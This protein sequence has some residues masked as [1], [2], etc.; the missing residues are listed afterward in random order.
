[1]NSNSEHDTFFMRRALEL[2]T[3]G[4]GMVAPNPMVGCVV[5]YNNQ[6]IGEGWHRQYGQPHAEVNAI[7]S[8]ADKSLLSLSTVYVTL[9]PCSH[10]GKTPPCA[11]LLIHHQVKRVV[12]CN[13]DINPL[14]G[15]KGIE[16]LRQ[17]GI[18]VTTGVLENEGR[19]LNRRFFCFIEKQRPYLILKWAESADGFVA[20]PNFEPTPISNQLSRKW[21]HQW[22]SQEDA[23]MVGTRTAL[24]DNPRLNVRDWSGRNPVRVVIDKQ[25]SLSNALH[26][27]DQSQPTL[28]YNHVQDRQESDLSWIKTP[29]EINLIDAILAN[30]YQRKIQSVLV[31]GGTHLL[32]SFLAQDLW[33]EIR[34]IQ[35]PNYLQ[36][37]IKAPD[38]KAT[39]LFSQIN[40]MGDVLRIYRR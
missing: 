23:I 19:V 34:V 20:K 36:E 40:L 15:G 7:A 4:Q 25:L 3:L 27:F 32:E 33:D 14:V 37:G 6:V 17:S 29:A 10:F 16:K 39:K 22:R 11:D 9:E 1:M 35:S 28:V 12:I 30:L 21:V 13:L 31:E 26:L 38:F 24:Y 2:A 5:V 8:V 18:D